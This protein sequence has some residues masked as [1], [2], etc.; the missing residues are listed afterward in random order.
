MST[1]NDLAA[2]NISFDVGSKENFKRIGVIIRR[3]AL[4]A[5]ESSISFNSHE[6]EMDLAACHAN[7]NP[8]DFEKLATAPNA[9]LA[10]DVFGIR[11][12]IDR[13]TGKLTE[14]FVPRCSLPAVTR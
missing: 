2:P 3:A 12:Y 10:H 14:C 5:A 9:D 8:L 6:L 7:G 11:K 1:V 13:R 4:I